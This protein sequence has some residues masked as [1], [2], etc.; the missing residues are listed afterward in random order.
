V[1]Y[2]IYRYLKFYYVTTQLYKNIDIFMNNNNRVCF[3]RRRR[4]RRYIV[5]VLI[6]RVIIAI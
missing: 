5:D 4:R 1:K 6:N 3:L 2:T